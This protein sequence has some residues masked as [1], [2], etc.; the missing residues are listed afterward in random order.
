MKTIGS[1]TMRTM[2]TAAGIAKQQNE[3]PVE[4]V[5]IRPSSTSIF[6]IDSDDRYK[7]FAQRQSSPT[8]PFRFSI[9]KNESL[10]NGYFKRLALT[11]FRMQWTLPNFSKAWKNTDM[12]MV[13]KVNGSGAE[14]TELIEIPD[15]FYNAEDLASALEADIQQYIPRFRVSVLKTMDGYGPDEVFSFSTMS[16]TTYYFKPNGRSPHRA[17]IDML[18]IHEP[19]GEVFKT[20]ELSGIPSLRPTDYIDLVCQQLTNNQSLKDATSAPITRDMLCRIYLDS[21]TPSRSLSN[22]YNY[23]GLVNGPN[24][25]TLLPTITAAVAAGDVVTYTFSGPTLLEPPYGQFVVIKGILTNT[26]YNGSGRVIDS[27]LV[28]PYTVTVRMT[29]PPSGAAAPSFGPNSLMSFYQPADTISVPGATWDDSV[30]STTP[31]ILYR[32]FAFPKQIRWN[33]AQPI[34]GV[35]FELFDDQGRSLQDLWESAYSP[36]SETGHKYAHSFSFNTTMLV[37][38]D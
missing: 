21:D 31:F 30:N 23:M 32:M 14:Q 3:D 2:A 24:G 29:V 18:N 37:S 7:D 9:A 10:L 27:T 17:L 28:L 25:S 11:E 5:T 34:G 12:L 38:E 16:T 19:L 15:G 8:Y 26:T 4:T 35:T 20:N 13:Y 1:S 6:A 33:A 22:T 36:S